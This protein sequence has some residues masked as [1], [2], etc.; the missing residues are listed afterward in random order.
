MTATTEDEL[1][2]SYRQGSRYATEC[3]C[4]LLIQSPTASE[5]DIA[6]AIRIHNASTVHQRWGAWQDALAEVRSAA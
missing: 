6:S 2:E 1:F 3:A 4:G 5:R